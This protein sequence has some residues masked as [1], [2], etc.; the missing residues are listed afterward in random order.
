[1]M[2]P[3]S[4]YLPPRFTQLNYA[5]K[6]QLLLVY[7]L[8]PSFPVSPRDF[9]SNEV[10]FEISSGNFCLEFVPVHI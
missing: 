10:M 2:G 4:L 5:L 8:H 3:V 9:C 7:T 1:M 6:L